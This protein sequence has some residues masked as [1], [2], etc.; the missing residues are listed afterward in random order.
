[1]EYNDVFAQYNE[2]NSIQE[3]RQI[4]P[5]Y[6]YT[7]LEIIKLV[8]KRPAT[9][10]CNSII[11]M[12]TFIEGYVYLKPDLEEQLREFNKWLI[13]KFKAPRNWGWFLV[14]QDN[15]DYEKACEELPKLF[16]EFENS[17]D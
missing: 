14:I 17:K 4:D 8:S 12:G 6:E 9:F 1:M 2:V 7:L 11:T 16:D 15:F 10:G 5:N 13:K 3:K